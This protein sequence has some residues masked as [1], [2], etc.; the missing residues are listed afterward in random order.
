LKYGIDSTPPSRGRLAAL[1]RSCG[2]SFLE[3]HRLGQE[4]EGKRVGRVHNRNHEMSA[5]N[6]AR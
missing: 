2:L 5:A 4:A 1:L 3:Q 6:A